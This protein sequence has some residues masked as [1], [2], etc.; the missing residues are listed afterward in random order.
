M[1]T[2]AARLTA[3]RVYA[4]S[5]SAWTVLVALSL[6]CS[7]DGFSP[8]PQSRPRESY[9]QEEIRPGPGGDDGRVFYPDRSTACDR[10]TQICYVG[11]RASVDA[12]ERH[13]GDDAARRLQEHVVDA[14]KEPKWVF[15]PDGDTSCDMRTQ[16][17]YGAKGPNVKQTRKYFGEEAAARLE[18]NLAGSGGGAPPI[19][20]PKKKVGCDASVQV[21]YDEN[22]PSVKL[23]K[24]Y[25]GEEAAKK[26]KKQ[27]PR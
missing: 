16:V 19:T 26:L 12:T 9:P 10:A 23:T 1:A 27:M 22:G 20:R 18:R 7:S 17:C 2:T 3:A 6:A 15:E 21:C 24:K 5:R 11:G 14:K 4:M 13:L 8:A 25:F